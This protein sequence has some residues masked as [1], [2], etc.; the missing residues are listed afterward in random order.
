MS[1]PLGV[2]VEIDGQDVIIT[3][4][5]I[6]TEALGHARE[7]EVYTE[8]EGIG[9]DGRPPIFINENELGRLRNS[10]PGVPVYGLWQLLF[11]NDKVTLGE[12]LVIFPTG[13]NSGIYLRLNPNADLFSP[14][15][16]LDSSEYKDN[17]IA[18]LPGQPMDKAIRLIVGTSGLFLPETPAYTRHERFEKNRQVTQRQWIVVGAICI[19][20]VLA[21]AALNYALYSIHTMKLKA[22]QS[23]QLELQTLASRMAE[24][25]R[26]RLLELPNDAVVLDRVRRLVEYDPGVRSPAT[27]DFGVPEGVTSNFTNEVHYL[28]TTPNIKTDLAE[29]Y[30][31]VKSAKTQA[32]TYVLTFERYSM[33]TQE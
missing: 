2:P 18:D 14:A 24:L 20:V 31:W 26:T 6:G 33:E 16:I 7:D 30:P 22:F 8:V 4:D 11:A 13:Q 32:G 10:Y 19:A 28:V 15:S 25:E 29:I 27:G 21:A 12:E 1:I 17:Y 3:R 5:V 9:E 23:K